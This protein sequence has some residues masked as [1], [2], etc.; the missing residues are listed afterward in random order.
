MLL[1]PIFNGF[2]LIPEFLSVC[3]VVQ[4]RSHFGCNYIRPV[5]GCIGAQ[6]HRLI[7]IR[8]LHPVRISLLA[9]VEK[10]RLATHQTRFRVKS[11]QHIVGYSVF[12][13]FVCIIE[14]VGFSRCFVHFP[15]C[16]SPYYSV[17]RY[18]ISAPGTRI[19]HNTVVFYLTH[20]AVLS[21]FGLHIGHRQEYTITDITR[22]H[23]SPLLACTKRTVGFNS[24]QHFLEREIIN[25]IAQ[26]IIR[27][28]TRQFR[29][30]LA[31]FPALSQFFFVRMRIHQQC[32]FVNTIA[33]IIL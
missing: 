26:H 32:Y 27:T 23:T 10:R 18:R 30:I 4:Y 16:H 5:M 22:P 14:P 19:L 17:G 24:H 20:Q 7:Y 12:N 31:K 6:I 29:N 25:S 13:Y 3:I 15:G 2:G 9:P 11:I 8:R 1:N 21:H 28:V 33:I